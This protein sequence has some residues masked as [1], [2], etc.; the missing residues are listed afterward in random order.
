MASYWTKWRRNKKIVDSFASSVQEVDS[1]GG[2]P[3]IL[4]ENNPA[5]VGDDNPESIDGND[6]DDYED[7]FMD[8]LEMPV[9]CEG[10]IVN[11]APFFDTAMSSEEDEDDYSSDESDTVIDE[12][13]KLAK[14]LCEWSLRNNVTQ[15]A[16]SDLLGT[17]Q[18]LPKQARTLLQTTK[19]V[20]NVKNLNGGEYLHFGILSYLETISSSLVC[21]TIRLQINIDGLS[22]FKKSSVQLWPIL[23]KVSFE[24]EPFVIGIFC[25]NSKPRDLEEYLADFVVHFF[26]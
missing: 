14:V 17:L 4:G 22:L 15:N 2:N 10:R 18:D 6:G 8:C 26:F 1:S 13:T 3:D 7:I 21:N 9:D 23:G 24:K 11:D 20:A 19:I 5:I 12:C 25:G 16:F